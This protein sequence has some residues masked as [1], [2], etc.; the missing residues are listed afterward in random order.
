M[1]NVLF[2]PVFVSLGKIM[3]GVFVVVGVG[4]T[5]EDGAPEIRI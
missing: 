5:D 1:D 3:L 2:V 4:G